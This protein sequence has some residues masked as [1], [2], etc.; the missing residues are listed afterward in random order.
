MQCWRQ[1]ACLDCERWI[2]STTVWLGSHP[3]GFKHVSIE[4]MRRLSPL[5]LRFTRPRLPHLTA[6]QSLQDGEL[7]P[8]PSGVALMRKSYSLTA[9]G[10]GA[11]THLGAAW[12]CLR[13]TGGAAALFARD[14]LCNAEFFACSPIGCMVA[15]PANHT[16]HTLPAPLQTELQV[17]AQ[18]QQPWA[19][20]APRRA[21]CRCLTGPAGGG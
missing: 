1:A 4:A 20:V 5:M 16:S 14:L 18:R 8:P 15:L 19:L 11:G 12:G 21:R 13:S 6:S 7:P 3:A 17:Q 2:H 10:R 9:A